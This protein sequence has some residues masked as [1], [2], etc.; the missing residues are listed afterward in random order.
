M[1]KEPLLQ[2]PAKKPDAR[3]GYGEKN[4]DP[5]DICRDNYNGELWH[6]GDHVT[7]PSLLSSEW[8]IYRDYQFAAGNAETNED[9]ETTSLWSL[10]LGNVSSGAIYPA[11]QRTYRLAISR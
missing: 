5:R 7:L 1:R 3:S 9:M 11:M 6:E 4:Y 2:R 10:R 8:F